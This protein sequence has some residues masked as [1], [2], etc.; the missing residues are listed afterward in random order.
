MW[1]TESVQ[2]H[3]NTTSWA[4][5]PGGL[6]ALLAAAC[7][8]PNPDFMER[9]AESMGATGSSGAV[10]TGVPGS[11][12]S[13]A[14]D[15]MTGSPSSTGSPGSTGS[16]SGASTD[17]LGTGTTDNPSTGSTSS[18]EPACEEYQL[19]FDAGPLDLIFVV[20][21]SAAMM[22]PW[23]HDSDDAT[24]PVAR[25][26][27]INHAVAQT[28]ERFDASIRAGLAL[29]PAKAATNVYGAAQC[30]VADPLDAGLALTNAAA[31][32]DALPPAAATVKGA[33][34][35]ATAAIAASAAV[36]A[37]HPEARKQVL[38]LT[39]GAGNCSAGAPSDQALLEA[40]DES[41]HPAINQ[42]FF[43][44]ILTHVIG[45]GITSVVSPNIVDS[46]PDGVDTYDKLNNLAQ[47]G[48]TAKAGPEK[49]WAVD[50]EA[51]LLAALDATVRHGLS[52]VLTLP[53]PAP[54]P[55]AVD[56]VLAG[57]EL[58]FITDCAGQHGWHY[59]VAGVY[60]RIELCGQACGQF[61]EVGAVTFKS[62]CQAG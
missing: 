3:R 47:L 60:D 40:Y 38:F 8:G 17:M 43:S 45:I 30:P 37:D 46:E 44:G 21:K 57:V 9:P 42:A 54:Q 14:A 39:G 33:R 10:I 34:P 27:S 5:V 24:P 50:D 51:E 4:L 26:T 31:I 12:T 28:A 15:M 2:G 23:D 61:Q 36:S 53:D 18:G 35:A 56:I 29:Y 20:D 41:L 13:S 25:W 16:P 19:Q 55:F 11:S 52:C 6:L 49:F 58:P 22:S 59:E 1:I 48:G 32:V 62:Y 7:I